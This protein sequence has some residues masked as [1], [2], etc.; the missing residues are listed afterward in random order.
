MPSAVSIMGEVASAATALAGLVL[1]FLGTTVNAFNS[2]QKAEQAS[3]RSKYQARAWTAF[4]CFLLSILSAALALMAKWLS[5]DCT[6]FF[7]LALLTA[8]MA[9]VVAA[10]VSAVREIK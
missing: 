2:Y 3:I 1:V 7:S 4:I 10:A 6:A 5:H 8:A 9:L